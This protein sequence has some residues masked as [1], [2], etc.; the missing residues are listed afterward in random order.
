V[1]GLRKAPR[2]ESWGTKIISL[3]IGNPACSVSYADE[4]VHDIILNIRTL[5]AI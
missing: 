5:Q 4:I 1:T 3:N 2:T